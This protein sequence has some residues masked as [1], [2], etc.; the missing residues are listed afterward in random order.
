M[1]DIIQPVEITLGQ[2]LICLILI[3]IVGLIS[4]FLNLRLE[5]DLILGTIRTFIQLVLVGY[6][7]EYIFQLNHPVLVLSYYGWMIFWAA[8]AVQARTKEQEIQVFTPTFV[9]M[10]T[11]YMVITIFVTQL[12]VRV[13]PWYQPQYFLTLG[14]MIIGNSM[15]AISIAL[16]RLLSDI[17]QKRQE[18]ELALSVGASYQQATQNLLR[19]AI[20]AGMIPSI[21]ALMT[22][23]LVSLPGMM[24]GQIL[25]GQPPT[26]AIRYQIIVM[27][28]IVAAVAIGCVIVVHIIRRFCFNSAHQLQI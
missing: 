11:S 24:T 27:L 18:I 4:I 8:R 28:M 20:H 12:I 23:G 2:M 17:R 22:V 21:N 14:G 3:V 5:K 26:E 13:E 6:I 10:I 25:A 1:N 15:T 16:G 19:D 9:S 7:L